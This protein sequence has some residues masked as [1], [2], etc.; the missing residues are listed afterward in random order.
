MTNNDLQRAFGAPPSNFE[1]RVKA[2]VRRMES[3]QQPV[4]RPRTV[5]ILA[6]MLL[7]LAGTGVALKQ[8][9][10]L[11][12]LTENLQRFLQPKAQELVQ[13]QPEQSGTQPEGTRFTV[14]EAINDGEQLYLLVRVA[15][16]QPQKTLLMDYDAVPATGRDWWMN[17][18]ER[19]GERFSTLAAES[20]RSLVQVDCPW[21]K[22][23]NTLLEQTR[24][25]IRYDGED[26]L[27]AFTFKGTKTDFKGT[28]SL[29]A[30]ELYAEN[31]PQAQGELTLN[32]PLLAFSPLYTA[33]T[34][35]A[36]PK[37]GGI[38]KR[39][40]V[41]QSPIATYVRAE[42]ALVP[43]VTD[44]QHINFEDGI[45]YDWLDEADGLVPVGNDV[46]SLIESDDGVMLHTA[47][48]A[49]DTLPEEITL[50]FYNGMTKERFDTVTL[51][52]MKEGD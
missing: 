31:N 10:V 5:L 1:N 9:G 4:F 27:Y 47:Y 17:H 50:E 39:L 34:P 33:Q 28:L 35:V 22:A 36:L 16:T 41:E 20:G 29:S 51:P 11:N 48:R 25:T 44:L 15:A 3:A 46:Q 21:L 42:Y 45:W 40:S 26:V 13:A 18:D 43:D 19:A 24:C 6:A 8:L 32:I 49:F 7:L 14:E 12:T 38:L 37:M 23:G 30:V 52:L 2:T